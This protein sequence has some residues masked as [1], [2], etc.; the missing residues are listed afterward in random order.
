[1]SITWSSK[2]ILASCLFLVAMAWPTSA[3][4]I[5]VDVEGGGEY[6]SI[7]AAIDA[8]A[9]ADEIEVGPG[10]YD[11]TV[12]LRG[13]AV[14]VYS[15]GGAEVTII[16]GMS[17]EGDFGRVVECISGEGP[18]TVLEGFTVQAE[19]EF[20]IGLYCEASGPTVLDCTF[21]G[22]RLSDCEEDYGMGWGM[23][24]YQSH[25]TVARCAFL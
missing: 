23:K 8:A 16:Q 19:E 20:G 13:K 2:S 18:G 17:N 6:T 22:F 11:G 7:Q 3:R 25:P 4:T 12:N 9:D 5:L 15:S 21:V 14:R 10:T 1:M 24:T